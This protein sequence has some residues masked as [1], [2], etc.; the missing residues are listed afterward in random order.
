M[1]EYIKGKIIM[2]LEQIIVFPF[3][4]IGY[5]AGY[6]LKNNFKNKRILFLLRNADIGGST[7]LHADIVEVLKGEKPVLV[8][9]KK[10]ANN[11]FL[12]RFINSGVSMYDISKWIDI[13]VLH[14]LNI[15]YR[16]ILAN[17]INNS[18]LEK[19]I[20]AEC[21][22]FYKLLPYLRQNLLR[23]DITH[24]NKWQHYTIRFLNYIDLRIYSSVGIKKNAVEQYKASG[25]SEMFMNK[26]KFIEYKTD[27]L[28]YS[29]P[30]NEKLEVIFIGRA[31]EQKRVHLIGRIAEG[32]FKQKLNLHVSFIGDVSNILPIADFPYCT[33]Y[34]N[35]TD[36][37]KLQNLERNSDVLLLTSLFEGLPLVVMEMMA[38]GRVVVSTAVSSIPDYIEDNI[39][40][41][42]IWSNNETEIV[43]EAINILKDLSERY[44]VVK[45]IGLN[46]RT[47]AKERF[48]P[49]KFMDEIMKNLGA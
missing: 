32:A 18:S 29:E 37:K 39:T 46:A 7:L 8:F 9:T 31:S 1:T 4:I 10:A 5:L 12:D 47:F 15:I 14:F 35:V 34:G 16:G 48:H 2:K 26:L 11:N 21:L 36:K 41:R 25:I 6:L 17:H 28:E 13:K 40:G 45:S 38:L 19:V 42:L 44:D 23:A 30:S 24:V 22:Y 49:E 20:G 33:F 43:E 3:I 27:I